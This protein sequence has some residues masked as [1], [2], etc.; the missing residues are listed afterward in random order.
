MYA[1]SVSNP[2]IIRMSRMGE[3]HDEQ[4]R[5][6]HRIPRTKGLTKGLTQQG[7]ETLFFNFSTW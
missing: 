3:E 1:I 6:P 2:K 4:A 7:K 5:G